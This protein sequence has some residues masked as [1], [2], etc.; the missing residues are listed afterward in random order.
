MAASLFLE[1][2]GF[3]VVADDWR[4]HGLGDLVLTLR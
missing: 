1:H 4:C 2:D 3:R